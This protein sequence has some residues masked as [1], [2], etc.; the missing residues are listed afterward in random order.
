MT[1]L[2]NMRPVNVILSSRPTKRSRI[3][4][5]MID[6]PQLFILLVETAGSPRSHASRNLSWFVPVNTNTL[7]EP[8]SLFS[9]CRAWLTARGRRKEKMQEIFLRSVREHRFITSLLRVVWMMG[10]RFFVQ[11]KRANQAYSMETNPWG[12][13]GGPSQLL[14]VPYR[15]GT[16]PGKTLDHPIFIPWQLSQFRD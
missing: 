1:E 14:R 3:H 8:L 11:P 13:P 16:V 15:R 5:F 4:W 6:S 12:L 10:G 2:I 7:D 9:D